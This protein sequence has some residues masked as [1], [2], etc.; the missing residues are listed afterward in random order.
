MKTEI[1]SIKN[2]VVSFFTDIVTPNKIISQRNRNIVVVAWVLVTLQYWM[3]TDSKFFPKPGDIL[4]SAADLIQNHG[5]IRELLVSTSTCFKSM[6]YAIL[7]SLVLAYLSVLPL[8]RPAVAFVGKNRFLTTIGLT[9]LF[10]QITPDTAH[11]KMSLLVFG[12]TVFLVTAMA[13]IV[14]EVTKEAK[15]HARTLKMHE[16]HVVWEVIIV[17]KADQMLEVIRQ[18]FAMAWM[19]LAF[20]EN[21]CRADGGIGIILTDQN[22]HFHLDAVYAIQIIVLMMGI[23]C[24]WILGVIRKIFCPY[25][26]LT[27][28]KK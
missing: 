27:L 17:G 21:I 6:G 13:A 18:N 8:F 10:S 26:Y 23:F 2:S 1:G 12:I 20:V 16:W 15:D 24:D 25:A 9:V 19:M 3:L 14:D 7:I 28:D 22:K 4:A 11:Q 5:L